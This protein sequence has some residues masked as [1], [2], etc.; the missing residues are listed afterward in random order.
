MV[1]LPE[2]SRRHATGEDGRPVLYR[3]LLY[4]AV[5]GGTV[6]AVYF[7][8][9]VPIISLLFGRAYGQAAGLLG[10]LGFGMLAYEM[11]MLM[12]YHDLA[13]SPS[14]VPRSVVV[15]AIL[16]PL[17]AWILPTSVAGMALLVGL[18]GLAVM[19]AAWLIVMR[20]PRTTARRAASLEGKQVA[21]R[22]EREELCNRSMLLPYVRTTPP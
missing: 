6:V 13:T 9:P 21:D 22:R 4:G 8:A 7:L 18:L 16:F 5:A 20:S 19:V 2:L 3:G 10:L 1:M 17:L 14:G 15:L 12:I 11:A